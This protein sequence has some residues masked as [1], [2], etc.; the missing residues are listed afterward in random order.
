[1][2]NKIV[3][4]LQEGCALLGVGLFVFGVYQIYPPAAYLVGGIVLATPFAL[5]MRRS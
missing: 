1:M 4:I 3:A 5:S 2:K